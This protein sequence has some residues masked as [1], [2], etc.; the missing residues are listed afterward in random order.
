M[1]DLVKPELSP[2]FQPWGWSFVNTRS[3]SVLGL[4]GEEETQR[5][6]LAVL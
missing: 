2:D 4:N 3:S 6:G 1:V 5:V